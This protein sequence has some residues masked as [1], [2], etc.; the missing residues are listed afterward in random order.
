[1]GS[2]KPLSEEVDEISNDAEEGE[3]KFEDPIEKIEEE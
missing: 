2:E 3:E 1:M